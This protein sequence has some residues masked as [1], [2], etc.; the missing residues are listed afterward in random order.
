M[1]F[2]LSAEAP[3]PGRLH[4]DCRHAQANGSRG[5]ECKERDPHGAIS[6][7]LVFRF[8]SI[9]IERP[10]NAGRGNSFREL[11]PNTGIFIPF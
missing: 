6:L 10:D 1:D 7:V 8:T 3:L 2:V 9:T 5:R 11:R 4:H